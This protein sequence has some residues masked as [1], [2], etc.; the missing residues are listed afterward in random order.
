[1]AVLE[2]YIHTYGHNFG[3]DMSSLGCPYH[4]A[5]NHELQSCDK[6][7]EEVWRMIS[8]KI[9]RCQ[10][11]SKEEKE[12]N[13][14]IYGKDILR[15]TPKIVFSVSTTST[16]PAP[17]L[18]I[19]RN[20][21]QLPITNT[22]VVPWNYNFQVY[23]QTASSSTSIPT[24]NHT[25][26]QPITTPKPCFTPHA[27]FKMTNT[28]PSNDSAP[29]FISEP[30][31]T[32]DSPNPEVE[33][34]TR[35]GRCYSTEEKKSKEKAEVGESPEIEE[36]VGKVVEEGES[37]GRKEED[38]LLLQIMKQSEY[39]VLDQAFVTLDITLG[40]FE[41]IIGQIQAFNFV[42][43]SEDEIDSA[44]L[45]HT[46]ALH[47]TV[48]CKGCLVAKVLIE[49]GA[50]L[51]VLPNETLAKVPV[52]PSGVRQSSI[53]VRA[54]D[55]KKRDVLGDIDLQLQIGACTF[56]VTFQVMDIEPAYTMFLG[57]PWIHSANAVPSTLH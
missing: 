12:V 44:S 29:Q 56:N 32:N 5:T 4:G 31:L 3:N 21:P 37:S 30:T 23:A 22:H 50:A 26:T 27:H 33:F 9:L 49:N 16:P 6:F 57:R 13:T 8:L 19:I 43:F 52:D 46:K 34:I 42:T 48:K 7:K 41:K 35:S 17:P 10:L 20:P 45:K 1:M 54:F 53:I 25:Y 36:K 47:V 39:D 55:G 14:A 2:G 18:T 15:S 51:N 38:E 11:K 24:L 40:Q 28:G